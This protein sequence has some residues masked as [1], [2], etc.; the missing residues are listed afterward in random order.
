MGG[1]RAGRIVTLPPGKP[2]GRDSVEPF[3]DRLVGTLPGVDGEAPRG[4]TR[5]TR[6]G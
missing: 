3:Q 5:P 1:Q 4:G 2:V 6:G